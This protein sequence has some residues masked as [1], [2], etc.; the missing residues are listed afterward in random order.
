M[1]LSQ[2]ELARRAGVDRSYMGHIE[3]GES[4]PTLE[5]IFELLPALE[6]EFDEWAR[7][8]KE[9]LAGVVAVS[10]KSQGKHKRGK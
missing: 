1:G 8:F 9:A 6:L 5:K 4:T 2:E 10:P 3:R 7:R